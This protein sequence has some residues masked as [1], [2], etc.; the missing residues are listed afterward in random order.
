MWVL[1]LL[2][3]LIV[4]VFLLYGIMKTKQYGDGRSFFDLKNIT[5]PPNST[6]PL[7]PY[8]KDHFVVNET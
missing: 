2:P 7:Y 5:V 6:M 1:L 3:S 8:R 4:S